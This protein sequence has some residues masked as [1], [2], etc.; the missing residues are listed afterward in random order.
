MVHFISASLLLLL[1]SFAQ[2]GHIDFI[3]HAVVYRP[4]TDDVRFSVRFRGDPANFLIADEH[5]RQMDAFS[6][7]VY[8]APGPGTAI[9]AAVRGSELFQSAPNIWIRDP[10]QAGAP[11][12]AEVPYQISPLNDSQ[13]LLDFNV[14]LSTLTTRYPDGVFPYTWLTTRY[15]SQTYHV[16]KT[17]EVGVPEPSSILLA[18]CLIA[19]GTF[20]YAR[21]KIL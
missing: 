1:A 9:D 14:S 6:F 3:G 17:S 15:G 13:M 16:F 19:A 11:V 20:R 10:Q 2:A 8:G 7:N 18:L 4:E 5:G 21:Q 12:V